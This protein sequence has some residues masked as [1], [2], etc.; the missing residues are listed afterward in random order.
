MHE[1]MVT[2]WLSVVACASITGDRNYLNFYS[3]HAI[4]YIILGCMRIIE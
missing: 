4:Q 1:A 3:I 2:L